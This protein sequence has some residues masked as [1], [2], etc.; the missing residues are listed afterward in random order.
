MDRLT[1]YHMILYTSFDVKT[2]CNYYEVG[3]KLVVTR[4]T[5]LVVF[6]GKLYFIVVKMKRELCSESTNK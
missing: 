5:S 2:I 3:G 4:L 6:F 1:C